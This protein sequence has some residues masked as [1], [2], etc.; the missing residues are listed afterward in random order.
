MSKSLKKTGTRMARWFTRL[1]QANKA[2]V[3]WYEVDHC[4]M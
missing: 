1:T 4:G 2:K 3:R